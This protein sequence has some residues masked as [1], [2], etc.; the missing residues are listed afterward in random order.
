LRDSKKYEESRS[1]KNIEIFQSN[2]GQWYFHIKG[3]N[4]EIIAQS[5][6]YTREADAEE[7]LKTLQ[8]VLA[9]S[10]EKEVIDG[11]NESDRA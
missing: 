5:E 4:G 2:G 7:G 9:E 3:D 1:M 10:E 8:R 6:A 11:R